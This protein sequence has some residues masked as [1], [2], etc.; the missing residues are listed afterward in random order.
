MKTSIMN[1]NAKAK[2]DSHYLTKH[3]ID[4][5]YHKQFF[6]QFI[7]MSDKLGH[8]KRHEWF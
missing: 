4:L 1:R 2:K 8:A 5:S 7:L 3:R 6:L